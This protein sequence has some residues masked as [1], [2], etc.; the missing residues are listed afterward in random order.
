[1]LDGLGIWGASVLEEES[2]GQRGSMLVASAMTRA[3]VWLKEVMAR[4]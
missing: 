2:I 4:K 1:M 3:F